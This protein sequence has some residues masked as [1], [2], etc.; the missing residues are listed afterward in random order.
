M[1]DTGDSVRLRLGRKVQQLRQAHRLSQEQ[2][3]ARVGNTSKHISEVELG[4][5][6]VSLDVLTAIAET[7]NV[8]I[9]ELFPARSSDDG[10][11]KTYLVTKDEVD[12]LEDVARI[13]ERIKRTRVR[14]SA[15]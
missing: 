2:L 12:R 3:A 11:T 9:A 14:R 8:E 7:F 10:R 5:A 6:N 13:V 15:K 4:K 1:A